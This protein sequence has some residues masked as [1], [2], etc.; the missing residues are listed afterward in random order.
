LKRRDRDGADHICELEPDHLAFYF[1]HFGKS[2]AAFAACVV[3]VFFA[4]ALAGVVF[5]V[6]GSGT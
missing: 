5:G 1:G 6:A 3:V 2:A 4:V